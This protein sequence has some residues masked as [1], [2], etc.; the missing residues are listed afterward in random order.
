VTRTLFC[1]YF[2]STCSWIVTATSVFLLNFT[3]YLVKKTGLSVDIA[4][5][6]IC[7][8]SGRLFSGGRGWMGGKYIWM[9]NYVSSISMESL[10]GL[11]IGSVLIWSL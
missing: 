7:C 3:W 5:Q 1:R 6:I 9:G 11:E 2:V 10:L 4:C 8:F